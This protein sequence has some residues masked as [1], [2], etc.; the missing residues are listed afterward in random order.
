M[1]FEQTNPPTTSRRLARKNELKAR[2]FKSL[3]D[4][5]RILGETIY[6][7]DM[8][9]KFLRSLPLEWKTHTLIWRN[10]PD[11][12]TLSMDDLYNNLKIYETEVKGSSSSNQNSQ[13][14]AFVSSNNSGSSNQAYGSN[15][16]KR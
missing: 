16:A 5:P 6:Q 13:N 3:S 9:L 4:T 15:S 1:E 14:V 12:D 2:G 7:K 10:K 11:L 8:N